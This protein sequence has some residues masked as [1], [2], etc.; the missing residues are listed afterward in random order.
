[1]L[2]LVPAKKPIQEKNQRWAQYCSRIYDIMPQYLTGI[3]WTGYVQ[4]VAAIP[5]SPSYTFGNHTD[6]PVIWR[7][8]GQQGQ[9]LGHGTNSKAYNNSWSI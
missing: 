6:R 3:R 9:K 1:M 5:T 8:F 7:N 2:I 4:A